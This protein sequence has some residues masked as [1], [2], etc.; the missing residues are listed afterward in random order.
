MKVKELMASPVRAVRPHDEAS[1]ARSQM[2]R[3]NI[4][5]MPVVDDEG[6]LEGVIGVDDLTYGEE[7]GPHARNQLPF[8]G[9]TVSTYMR[10]NVTTLGPEMALPEAAQVLGERRLSWVPV[11]AARRRVVG[12]VAAV[13]LLQTLAPRAAGVFQ[14]SRIVRDSVPTVHRHASLTAVLDRLRQHGVREALVLEGQT[15]VDD[16][17]VDDAKDRR[18]DVHAGV[19][20]PEHGIVGTIDL[21]AALASSWF[22]RHIQDTDKRIKQARREE[23]GG[24]RTR[25]HVDEV[26]AVAE[27]VMR[28]EVR[29]LR[30]Q[31]DASYAA[32]VFAETGASGLPVFRD[33]EPGWLDRADLLH[34]IVEKTVRV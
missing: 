29:A 8:L 26:H 23:N 30:P 16:R 32:R 33:G 4:S 18:E 21:K 19:P 28:R 11:V 1:H 7:T 34:A 13:D 24:D 17:R 12:V 10:R 3:H 22:D 6:R 9:E 14:V 5:H 27:N 15:F 25:R 2:V 20:A 31:D